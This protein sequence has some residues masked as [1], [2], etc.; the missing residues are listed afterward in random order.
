VKALL[1]WFRAVR[2]RL[3]LRPYARGEFTALLQVKEPKGFEEELARLEEG[4]VAAR[5]AGLHDFRLALLAPTVDLRHGEPVPEGTPRVLVVSLVF[6]GAVDEVLGELFEAVPDLKWLFGRCHGFEPGDYSHRYFVR[7]LKHHRVRHDYFFRDLGPLG[8][9][10][11]RVIGEF[12][13][14]ASRAEIEEAFELLGRLRDFSSAYPPDHAVGAVREAFLQKFGQASF[15]LPLTEEERPVPGEARWVRRA[16]EELGRRQSEA[17]RR[18]SG[19]MLRAAHAKTTGLLRATFKVEPLPPEYRHGVFAEPREIPALIRL[20]NGSEIVQPDGVRDAR[21]L[22]IALDLSDLLGS[23]AELSPVLPDSVPGRQDFVLFSHPTFFAASVRR[24]VMF[25]GIARNQSLWTRLAAALSFS[26]SRSAPRE[27]AAGLGALSLR[28]RHALR[29]EYHSGTAYRLGRNFVVKYSIAVTE[30]GRF[31]PARDDT[32]PNY[33][34]KALRESLSEPVELRFFL[35]LLPVTKRRIGSKSLVDLV[36]DPTLDW[37]DFGAERVHAATLLVE[38]GALDPSEAE[39]LS[40]D[41]WNALA[42]HRPLGNLN[43]ARWLAY[44]SSARRRGASSAA[45][46]WG[47]SERRRGV[48]RD[49]AE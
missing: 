29:V 41:V 24:L 32:D 46:S 44:A 21:G 49:A 34:E 17:A 45:H 12:D 42:A 48:V 25:L 7:R 43:R 11:R 39:L 2:D 26:S 47:S 5:V 28:P 8:P 38:E 13:G 31:E 19:V 1:D 14:D 10:A 20:S 4:D 36:E 37:A 22:A 16:S 30:P 35:H 40:F 33:L 3:T 15:P 18:S 27:V 6:D 23:G 9:S